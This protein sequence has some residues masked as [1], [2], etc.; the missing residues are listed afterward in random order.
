MA[1]F[2]LKSG[3]SL[4]GVTYKPGEFVELTTAQA[5]HELA[6]CIEAEA[7][8]PDEGGEVS[9][10]KYAK[11]TK[12]E[13]VA[14]LTARGAEFDPNAKNDDLKAILEGLDSASDEGGAE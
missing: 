1:K 2:K 7:G 10:S 13:L 11:L 14:E 4:D 6:E 3:L 12:K 9:G 8:I 5:K